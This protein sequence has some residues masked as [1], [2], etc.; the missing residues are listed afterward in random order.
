MK[1][2]TKGRVSII[3]V[4]AFV[5]L[6]GYF[7]ITTIQLQIDKKEKEEQVSE[8]SQEIAE[9]DEA[10]EEIENILNSENESEYM[11]QYAREELDY[12]MP[13]ERVYADSAS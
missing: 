9:Q 5:A 2:R 4:L 6:V 10:N 11:E 7:V 3:L 13:G 8:L 12:I 1:K